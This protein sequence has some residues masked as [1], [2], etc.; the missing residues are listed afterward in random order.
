[1]DANCCE[2]SC[3]VKNWIPCSS[4]DAV[5]IMAHSVPSKT[6]SSFIS[7]STFPCAQKGTIS[8]MLRGWRPINA[9]G[10]VEAMPRR[11]V[12]QAGHSR[13]MMLRGVGAPC[14][15]V[16]NDVVGSMCH[17]HLS[18]SG[19]VLVGLQATEAL[20]CGPASQEVGSPLTSP[21][22]YR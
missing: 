3:G 14:N 2:N 20:G 6:I 22:T 16:P 1:M 17:K 7:K 21:S 12:R 15:S 13:R 4:Y 9:T 19:Q 11:L 10:S 8:R 18:E 5:S